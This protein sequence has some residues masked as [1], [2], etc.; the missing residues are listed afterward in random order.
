MG[1]EGYLELYEGLLLIKPFVDLALR[2]L[3]RYLIGLGVSKH[4]IRRL[5]REYRRLYDPQGVVIGGHVKYNCKSE[6]LTD[7]CGGLRLRGGRRH[8]Q[9]LRAPQALHE[10]VHRHHHLRRTAH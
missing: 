9:R 2:G 8:R 7:V 10:G 3:E 6:L 4:F 1:V 5:K